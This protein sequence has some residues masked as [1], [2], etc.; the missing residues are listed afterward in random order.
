[1]YMRGIRCP[2]LYIES[3]QVELAWLQ[4]VEVV[5]K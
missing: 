2:S 5:V 1:M 4:S 3:H